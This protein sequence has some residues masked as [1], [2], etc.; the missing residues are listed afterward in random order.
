MTRT[1][2]FW[3]AGLV[4]VAPFAVAGGAPG[5][6]IEINLLYV[7]GVKSCQAERQ[8]AQG[9][10]TD[11]EQAV[12]ADLP[13]RIA[14]YQ[15]AHPGTTI[16]THSG[17]ANLYTATPSGYH[18]SDSP[19]PINMD[20]WKVGDPGCS[21]TQQGDPCTTAYEWRYRL[22]Q[23]IDRLYPAPASNVILIGHSSGA[24]V[25]L[26]VAANVGTGGVGSANWGV[27][28]LERR[29][30]PVRCASEPL[31]ARP[32][33]D[34]G[35]RADVPAVAWAE[36]RLVLPQR[37][38]P[39]RRRE[40]RRSAH[41]GQDADPRLALHGGAAGRGHRVELDVRVDRI[42]PVQQHLHDGQHLSIGRGG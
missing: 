11:L 3:L 35:T 26:E 36:V 12:N 39:Q 24:R 25:A 30:A 28:G 29:V 14:S 17:R 18:P 2:A 15:A 10:F 23:E 38:R 13:G 1:R 22:A 19:D 7:H 6:T 9:S 34:A 27:D 32:R 41:R 33:H 31:G 20:D 37:D 8:N 4:L 16:V 21:T 42:Q 5:A 40:P